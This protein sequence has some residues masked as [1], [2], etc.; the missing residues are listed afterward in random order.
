MPN[1]SAAAPRQA[2]AL[3]HFK[4]PRLAYHP[5]VQERFGVDKSGWM[6][7]ID[8]VFPL[9]TSIDS[10]ILALSY[11]R[12]RNLDP[13]KKPVHIVP[14]WSKERGAYVDTVWPGIGEL[15]T[16]A[17]RT[18]TYA[19]CDACVFGEDITKRF[20]GTVGKGD[21]ARNMSVEVTFPSWA[22][23]T[24]YRMIDGQRVAVQ[25][26][27]V[28][29]TETYA[30]QGRSVVPN[31]MWQKRPRG[32][33]EKCAEAAALRRAF[34][35]ELGNEYAAEEM[36]GRHLDADTTSAP[37]P[38]QAESVGSQLDEFAAAEPVAEEPVEPAPVD[39]D[40][41]APKET[42]LAAEPAPDA[43]IIAYATTDKGAPD[44]P[45][46]CEQ[47]YNML[48]RAE[49]LAQVQAIEAQNTGKD[50]LLTFAALQG[51]KSAD[52]KAWADDMVRALNSRKADL[53]RPEGNP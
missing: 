21:K 13:F 10:V 22:Q 44:W 11:C 26:P 20:D 39:D 50:R 12:A 51:K 6:A 18:K 1:E 37:I 32:Q 29:W 15:R 3:V 43:Y 25:G 7:L 17:F 46:M 28:Y 34:P 33:L 30:A 48:N 24:V 27:R 35:E 8:A 31:E 14:M 42:A 19:G 49:T 47:F 53:M 52:V 41:V 5:M 2:A 16:T 23:L 45:G 38:V 40:E 36:S 4:P 9:A